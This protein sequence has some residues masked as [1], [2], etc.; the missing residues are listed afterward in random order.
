M[1][2]LLV[3]IVLLAGCSKPAPVKTLASVRV[4]LNKQWKDNRIINLVFHGHSVPAG[5]HVT[6]EIKPFES[7]PH[8]VYVGLKKKYPYAQIN[9]IVTA[10]GGETSDKGAMRFEDEVMNHKPD[11]LFIDYALNDRFLNEQDSRRSLSKMIDSAKARNVIVVLVT[12]TGAEDANL[13]D[14][15]DKLTIRVKIIRELAKEKDC[16]L[17]DVSGVW[18]TKDQSKLLSQINHPNLIGH[19]LAADVILETLNH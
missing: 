5:F 11:I 10:V 14:E 3:F 16:L 7:Y 12:P 9:C 6:P 18:K 8:L 1:K 15:S 2:H 17:A 13:N 4:E 19:Q